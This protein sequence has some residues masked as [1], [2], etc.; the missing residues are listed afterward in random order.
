M[1]EIYDPR[2]QGFALPFRKAE[3]AA[4]LEQVERYRRV[5][6]TTLSVVMDWDDTVA[7]GTWPILR[8][9][10]SPER[11]DL[12]THLYRTYGRMLRENTI[13]PEQSDAWQSAAL[14]CL[15]GMK[16]SEIEDAAREHGRLR[17]GAKELFDTC[18]ETG[19]VT[20][21]RTAAIEQFV[22]AAADEAGI[23]PDEIIATRLTANEEGYITGWIP[24]TMTHSHNKGSL[25]LLRTEH[26]IVLGD[27]MADRYMVPNDQ[28]SLMIRA[29]GGYTN[30]ADRWLSYLN[31]SFEADPPYDMVTIE[32]NLI[33]VSGLVSYIT[34]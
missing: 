3:S 18:A 29:N 22:K 24:D 28:D 11:R 20:S 10:M 9:I 34:H 21:I 7:E 15:V 32:P 30:N 17:A 12:H 14:G 31:E 26:A 2:T 19:V 1:S 25:G 23:V 16:L 5:G 27:G 6:N 4:V 13:T 8:K 33:A